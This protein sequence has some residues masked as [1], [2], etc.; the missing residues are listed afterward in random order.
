MLSLF[1]CA[2][3]QNRKSDK[4]KMIVEKETQKTTIT[5]KSNTK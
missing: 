3:V 2:F 1:S 5:K 4:S